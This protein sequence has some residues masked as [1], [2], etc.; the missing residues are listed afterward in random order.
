MNDFFKLSPEM[1][2]LYQSMVGIDR[3]M[4]EIMQQFEPPAH[5]KEAMDNIRKGM[6]EQEERIRRMLDSIKPKDD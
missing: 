6:D 4:K 3:R 2:A 5:V 1:E